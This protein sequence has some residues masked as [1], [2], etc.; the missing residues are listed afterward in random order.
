M[1]DPYFPQNDIL[2]PE[3]EIIRTSSRNERV[4]PITKIP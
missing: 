1:G 4:Y 3:R 2:R